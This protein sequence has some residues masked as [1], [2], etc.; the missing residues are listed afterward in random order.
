MRKDILAW[1]NFADVSI[2]LHKISIKKLKR[3]TVS[4]RE[5]L[6]IAEAVGVCYEQVF[7]FPNGKKLV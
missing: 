3:N 5:M 6:V 4:F 1:Q 2:R 7:M